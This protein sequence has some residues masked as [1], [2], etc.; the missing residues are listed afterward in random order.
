MCSL[1]Y[2]DEDLWKKIRMQVTEADATVRQVQTGQDVHPTQKAFVIRQ[3]GKRKIILSGI[4]WGYPG[5]LK[6]GTLINARVETVLEKKIFVNGIHYHRA[7]IPASLF[8]EW[9]HQKEKNSFRRQD[10]EPLYFAGFFDMIDNE[11]SFVILTTQANESMC[12][13]HDRMPLILEKDQIRDWLTDG[14]AAEQMLHQIP[15]ELTR[16]AEYEQMTL[17]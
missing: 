5:I 1:F 16:K 7:V 4:R 3:N 13:V 2:I 15:T 11:E 8:Y 12:S 9:N 17:F 6:T 14:K 10:G